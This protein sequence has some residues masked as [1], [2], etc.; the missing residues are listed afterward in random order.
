MQCKHCICDPPPPR[1]P[2]TCI[3]AVD[4]WPFNTYSVQL[5]VPPRTQLT[6]SS[7]NR[8][9]PH[10][11]TSSLTELILTCVAVKGCMGRGGRCLPLFGVRDVGRTGCREMWGTG[12]SIESPAPPSVLLV[13]CLLVFVGLSACCAVF[14]LVCLSLFRFAVAVLGCF[15]ACCF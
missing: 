3:H 1:G 4:V 7:Y 6:V 2:Q 14:C 12:G 13:V 10:K 15:A 11:Y 5:I 9:T 8:I